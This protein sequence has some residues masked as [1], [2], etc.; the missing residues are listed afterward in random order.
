M[1][2]ELSPPLVLREAVSRIVLP[3]ARTLIVLLLLYGVAAERLPR[4]LSVIGDESQALPPPRDADMRGGGGLSR[5]HLCHRS[6]RQV[7]KKARCSADGAI[8][9]C[10]R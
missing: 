1:A 9:K 10:W 7:R 5:L 8:R 2:K 3:P 4:P 6:A